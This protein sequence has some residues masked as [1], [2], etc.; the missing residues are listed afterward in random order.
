M[1]RVKRLFVWPFKSIRTRYRKQI[2]IA[3]FMRW[4]LNGSLDR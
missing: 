3:K 2:K 1:I 4:S